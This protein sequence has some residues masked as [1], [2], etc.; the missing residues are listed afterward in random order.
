MV[1]PSPDP[2][3]TVTRSSPT[4]GTPAVGE[5]SVYGRFALLRELG[6]GGMGVVHEAREVATGRTVA[7][8]VI[9]VGSGDYDLQL[10]LREARSMAKVSH[11]NTVFLFGAELSGSQLFLAMEVVRGGTVA[12]LL[13]RGGPLPAPHAVGVALQLIDGLRAYAEHGI[14]HRD[15][16]PSNCFLDTNGRA[17][18]GDLG[19]SVSPDTAIRL[20]SAGRFLGTPH[21]SSPEQLRGQVVDHRSDIYALGATLYE[22]IAGRPPIQA[23]DGVTLVARIMTDE[24]A[25][26]SR[27]VSGV[28]RGLDEIIL[29]SLAK[30]AEARFQTYD[31]FA[32]ALAPF[33]APDA[34]VAGFPMRLA[35]AAGDLG[36]F[37]LM[38]VWLE[39]LAP[40]EPWI[41]TNAV[42]AVALVI[43]VFLFEVVG[44]ASPMKAAAGFRIV[45][46]D[47]GRASFARVLARAFIKLAPM[48][49]LFLGGPNTPVGPVG[50]VLGG[51]LTLV[52]AG[53]MLVLATEGQGVHDWLAGTR[54]VQRPSALRARSRSG[55]AWIL[56]RL[57]GTPRDGRRAKPEAAAD[58]ASAVGDLPVDLRF[59][60]FV[61]TKRLVADALETVWEAQDT[62][63]G[64]EVWVRCHARPE[65][66]CTDARRTIERASRMR[67]LAT[68]ESNAGPWDAFEVP[69]IGCSVWACSPETRRL[70]WR[71]VRQIV[72]LMAAEC[73][74]A[75]RDGTTPPSLSL[76]QVIVGSH[77]RAVL[78][79][80]PFEP[81]AQDAPRFATD[82]EGLRSFLQVLI[83]TL[84]TGT[85]FGSSEAAR[86]IHLTRLPVGDHELLE[87]LWNTSIDP[88]DAL[89]LLREG[90]ADEPPW[91]SEVS[92]RSRV[93]SIAGTSLI[94]YL[95]WEVIQGFFRGFDAAITNSDVASSPVLS[96]AVALLLPVT[97]ALTLEGGLALRFQRLEVRT[98]SG[99]PASQWHIV[100]RSLPLALG[101]GLAAYLFTAGNVQAAVF[102]A[103]PIA[104]V[105]LLR[106]A[107]R[108]TRSL[109]DLLAGT[110]LR[111]K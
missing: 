81:Q 17:R 1:S 109:G 24:P 15:I 80:R 33:A 72:S 36:I 25:P 66:R 45:A 103:L 51:M 74:A 19:I 88:L 10:A 61:V 64:R 58:R 35:A 95:L 40:T 60:A 100:A 68:G 4:D 89:L 65:N 71:A 98:L 59:G 54:V 14:V 32:G 76:A 26:P 12:D 52:L 77:D 93:A 79:D 53:S 55:W 90:L 29:R 8:K 49:L 5:A 87:N 18:I 6:R 67:W 82:P 97:S 20:T 50:G 3:L 84:V 30:T 13:R 107:L 2:D 44:R 101:I 48:I 69:G 27:H 96:G 83:C 34:P 28:P 42:P 47:G 91:S 73:L 46:R 86:R 85:V 92:G 41:L 16:K 63:L 62:L 31:D 75:R 38:Q 94:A 105:A 110:I 11:P 106:G 37:T 70:P 7:L 39:W 99:E 21:Y 22:M 102:V 43:Y 56:R 104:L 57:T 9:D 108:P 23:P 78:L 111:P